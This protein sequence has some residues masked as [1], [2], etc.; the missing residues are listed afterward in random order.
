[1]RGRG[2]ILHCLI[3][4]GLAAFLLATGVPRLFAALAML[5]G[6]P[7]LADIEDGKPVDAADVAT[8]IDSRETARALIADPRLNLDIALGEMLRRGKAAEAN[9]ERGLLLDRAIVQ[10]YRGLAEAP[11][12]SFAW[13]RLALALAQRDGPTRAA[14]AAWRLSIATA[15]AEPKLTAWRARFAEPLL[16]L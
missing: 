14:L 3:F 6:D 4:A 1:M 12:N 7:V 16:P 2:A 5:P 8:M 9:P 11:T 10:L 15:P 13:A